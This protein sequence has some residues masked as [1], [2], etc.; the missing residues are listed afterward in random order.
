MCKIELFTIKYFN[1]DAYY[2]IIYAIKLVLIF[3]KNVLI[4]MLIKEKMDSLIS[5]KQLKCATC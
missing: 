4:L 3:N 2:L 1:F 5:T